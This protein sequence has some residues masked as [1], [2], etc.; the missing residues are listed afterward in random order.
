MDIFEDWTDEHTKSF[1]KE[2][3]TVRHKIADSGLFTDEALA[4]ML[5][6]HP[7]DQLDV[8]TMADDQEMHPNRFRTGDFRG[9]DGVTL[10]EAAKAGRIWINARKA[11]NIHPEYKAVLDRMYGAIGETTGQPPVNAKG[12]ILISSPAAKVPYHCDR[13]ETILW[14]VRGKKRMY[15]YPVTEEFLP[16][17]VYLD[18]ITN[19]RLDDIPYTADMD[20][21]AAVFDLKEGE[22]VSWPLHAPHRV[23][24][25]SYCVSVTTEY[26]TKESAFKNAFMFTN[27]VLKQRFGKASRW[28]NASA[29]EKFVKAAAGRVLRKTKAYK[30]NKH[31]AEDYVDFKIDKSVPGYVVDIKPFLRSF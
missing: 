29:S 25:R 24:N 2:I 26:S 10:I 20:K 5:D 12:G 11:M 15:L 23:D 21:S 13:T 31:D 7:S 6:K 22:M 4:V 19:D 30:R 28:V 9:C 3:I 27:A 8:C 17:E 16:E 1:R 14:H 18:I